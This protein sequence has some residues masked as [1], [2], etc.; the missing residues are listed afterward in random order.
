MPLL[1]LICNRRCAAENGASLT[2]IMKRV[3]G[4]A[5]LSTDQLTWQ[6]W[7]GTNRKAHTNGRK[8]GEYRLLRL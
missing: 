8:T 4:T 1:F 2:V 7:P 5:V 3:R 6:P